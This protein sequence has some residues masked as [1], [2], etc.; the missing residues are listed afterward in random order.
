MNGRLIDR[1]YYAECG[2]VLLCDEEGIYGVYAIC[3]TMRKL[4]AEVGS[5]GGV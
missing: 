2:C 4:I 5:N 3:T 1:L